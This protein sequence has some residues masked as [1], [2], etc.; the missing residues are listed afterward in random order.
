MASRIGVAEMPNSSPRLGAEYTRPGCI[1]P[2]MI[3]DRSARVTV[4]RMLGCLLSRTR[5]RTS[6]PDI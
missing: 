4:S 5:L 1:S 2:L 3:A 6:L